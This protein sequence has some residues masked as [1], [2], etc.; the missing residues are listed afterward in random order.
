[1]IKAAHHRTWNVFF[2]CYIAWNLQC[3]FRRVRIFGD[4]K[5]TGQPLL[6]LANHFS[7]WDGFIVKYLNRK[8]FAKKFHVMMLEEQ[9]ENRRFLSKLGAFSIRKGSRSVLDSLQYAASL[10]EKENTMLLYFPQGKFYSHQV[11]NISFEPGISMLARKI[12]RPYTL[13]FTC[14][15]IDYFEDKKPSLSVYFELHG[16]IETDN[17]LEIESAYNEFYHKCVNAQRP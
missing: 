14:I 2:D 9:L 4:W 8:V 10:F 15:L 7:W 12:Q 1:M 13:C 17:Y 3:H 5:D 11:G 6:V 16:P